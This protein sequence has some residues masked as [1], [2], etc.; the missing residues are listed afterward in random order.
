MRSVDS[1]VTVPMRTARSSIAFRNAVDVVGGCDLDDEAAARLCEQRGGEIVV[2]Q[3][4]DGG[5][6]P[7][8]DAHLGERHGEAA[9]ADVVARLDQTGADRG[10]QAAIIGRSVGY[11]CGRHAGTARSA[12][13]HVEMR[14]GELGAGL[15][16]EEQDVAGLG[17]IG[18]DAV[19][20]VGHVGDRGD[21]QRGWHGVALR[22]RSPRTRC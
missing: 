3:R 18:R 1:S 4:V 15:A 8:G 11:R 7:A 6:E 19:V 13:H 9:F 14:T 10:V 5:A 22:R 12:A 16:D 17:Q 20:G 21:H 2:G